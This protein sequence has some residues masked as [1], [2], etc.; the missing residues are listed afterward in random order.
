M[1]IIELFWVREEVVNWGQEGVLI[2]VPNL[3]IG[4]LRLQKDSVKSD[5]N[6]HSTIVKKVR[7]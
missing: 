7:P 3:S 2:F 4:R 5:H 1:F 6:T